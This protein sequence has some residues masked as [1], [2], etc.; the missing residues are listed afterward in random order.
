MITKTYRTIIQKDGKFYRGFV[1]ALPGCHSYGKT[2]EETQ[3]N[4]TE[5]IEG[6]I[7]T[8]QD[9]S[10]SIPDDTLIETLQTITF[11]SSQSAYA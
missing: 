1:P 3:D 10:W 4:L 9:L 11:P 5:A 6:W 2:I 7:S 8:R